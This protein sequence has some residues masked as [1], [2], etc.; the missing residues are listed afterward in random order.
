MSIGYAS[1]LVSRLGPCHLFLDR[2]RHAAL[3]RELVLQGC[4]V[5]DLADAATDRRGPDV[6]RVGI[7]QWPGAREG[8]KEIARHASMDTLVLISGNGARPEVD[9]CLFAN[10][11]ERH[12]AGM[13]P[14]EHAAFSA[15]TLP[16]IA[17]YRRS[18]ANRHSRSALCRTGADA[19][20]FIARYM[21]LL[22][23]VRRGDHVLIDGQH[24]ADAAALLAT[25]SQARA[26]TCVGDRQVAA[27]DALAMPVATTPADLSTVADRSLDVVVALEPT[28]PESWQARLRDYAR[29]LRPDGRLIVGWRSD[30]HDAA[31]SAPANWQQLVEEAGANFLPEARIVQQGQGDQ[32]VLGRGELDGRY[33]SDWLILIASANLFDGAADRARFTH[34]AF[35]AGTAGGDLPVVVDFAG[36]Y[37]NPYLYRS[38]IQI[39]ER[40]DN[41]VK[42][43]E[44]AEYV[45][46]HARPGSADQGAAIG[47]LG[48]RVLEER[49]VEHVPILVS[50]IQ[51]YL[52]QATGNEPHVLRWRISLMFLAGRLSELAEARADA[53]DWYHRTSIANWAGFSPLIATKSIGAAFFEGRLHLGDGDVAAAKVCFQRGVATALAAAQASHLDALGDPERPVPFYLTELAEVMDMGSQCANAVANLPMWSRDPGTFWRTVDIRRFG[54]NNWARDLQRENTQ[55]RAAA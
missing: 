21:Q 11:W 9:A 55:L 15:A 30:D 49:L 3:V 34:P 28:V 41:D 5:S 52:D 37:D 33:D 50:V 45:I 47:V 10:G 32:H 35:P 29:V 51:S 54:L 4:A 38:M 43:G 40:F 23:Y 16:G 48:Y 17:Y 27:L 18:A 6:R 8:A 7:L 12:G 13:M 26:L 14:G 1:V 24:F 53:V 42:L 31:R 44:I 2:G 25:L 19:D 22:P 39:G 46:E 20:R 36:S